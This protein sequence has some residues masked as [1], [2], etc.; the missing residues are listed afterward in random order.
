MLSSVG[1]F[2]DSSYG[3][4]IG[5]GPGRKL[6]CVKVKLVKLSVVMLGRC[7]LGEHWDLWES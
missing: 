3:L 7:D 6:D 5:R 2:S 1:L 4:R